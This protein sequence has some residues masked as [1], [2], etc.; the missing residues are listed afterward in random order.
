[1]N[2]KYFFNLLLLTLL[3]IQPLISQ[4]TPFN[5]DYYA[6]L[7]Q[8]NDVFA[9]D[10]ASGSAYEVATDIT[11]GDINGAGYNPKDGYIWGSLTY[12]QK[13]IVRIGKN[14]ST[15]TY[16]IDALP[17]S[18]RYIGDVSHE[19][20]YYSKS[21][22]DTYYIIDLDP[23]SP[24]HLTSL[25]TGTL[26]QSILV[27]D[28]AFNS[29]DNHLYTVEK[30]TNKLYRINA[31]TG[32]VE[33]LGVVP[34]LA[35]LNYTYGAVYFDNMGNFYVSA[36]QTG[37]VYI[38]NEVTNINNGSSINSNLF[39]FGPSSSSNDGARCPTAPVPMEDCTNGIDDDG[40]GLADCDDPSCSGVSACPTIVAPTTSGNN[41]G[42]ESNNRLSQ[43][44]NKRNYNR[45][46]TNYTFRKE[47]AKRIVKKSTYAQ[48][49]AKKALTLNDFIPLKVINEDEAIESSPTDLIKITNA[50]DIVSVDYQRK[51]K[52]VASI[53]ALKTEDKVYE[54]TKYICDRLLGAE[55]LSVSTIQ[56]E[57]HN[58]IKSIIK[59]VDGGVEFVLSLSAR[60]SS[61]NQ[62]FTIENHWNL[63][64]YKSETGYFNFQIWSNSID[65]LMLLSTEVIRLLDVKK[66]IDTY[67]ISPPPPVFVKKGFYKNGVL[68]LDIVNVNGSTTVEFDAGFKQTETSNLDN[69]SSTIVL[70]KKYI[71]NVILDTGK[72][73]DIG[74]RIGDGTNT[75]D[76]LFMS[77]GSWGV[78]DAATSTN[79]TDFNVTP[80][81]DQTD[82]TE[83]S[84]ERNINLK[85]STKEY[86]SVYKAFNPR[87]KPVDI[88][89]FNALK[90]KGNGTGTLEVRF[91]K[92]S[93]NVWEDQFNTTVNLGTTNQEYTILF[94]DFISTK[95]S[96]VD[97]S[98]VVTLVFT[99]VSKN[100]EKQ[101]KEMNISELKLVNSSALS[102]NDE[103]NSLTNQISVTPN[104]MIQSANIQF[105]SSK[106]QNG[107]LILYNQLG[108]IIQQ[109]DLKINSGKNEVTI[110]RNKLPTGVYFF[111]IK[112]D[113]LNYITKKL[114]IK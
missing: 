82:D 24:T 15:T 86:V 59:N 37:T 29:L 4:N 89:S 52:T 114:V 98:D 21:G 18:N 78:D 55:L 69:M 101:V 22:G 31:S 97:F 1:M 23:E 40:D 49:G 76:D 73:F 108:Q 71:S 112:S 50:T 10:L 13:S 72:L 94:D 85:A 80:N 45:I 48:K 87:F 70:D 44:I 102:T 9:V 105:N 7:F 57:D 14:F 34:A 67:N 41:G 47:T 75:P 88:S 95:S 30:G 65:D 66:T 51:N 64:K 99:M 8:K 91:I 90:F 11:T 103:V 2:K 25:G 12:P 53:L 58:F 26:S 36:N 56:I 83:M 20:I 79:V 81:E 5:C 84:I 3:S 107:S 106:Y 113:N 62:N 33:N 100:G 6:Y 92:E 27:H 35:G 39:A 110:Y 111:K 60:E 93:I 19:G 54:H 61:N 104:P 42:L 63:D 17:T 109:R 28:W 43:Q 77:D 46:K 68:N 74:F 32:N 96:K 38:I 16:T